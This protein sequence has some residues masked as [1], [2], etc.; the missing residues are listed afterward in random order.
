MEFENS[1]MNGMC[2][3]S[4]WC[5]VSECRSTFADVSLRRWQ[6]F[7]FYYW[8]EGD[9]FCF[10][11]V[12]LNVKQYIIDARFSEHSVCITSDTFIRASP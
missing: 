4:F 7:F 9:N 6:M 10:V 3:L 1:G 11:S 2:K 8:V 5:N 12:P